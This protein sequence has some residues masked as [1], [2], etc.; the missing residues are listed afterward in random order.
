MVTSLFYLQVCSTP[1]HWA[2]SRGHLN[3]AMCLIS[4]GADVNAKDYVRGVIYNFRSKLLLV[5]YEN[6]SVLAKS[7]NPTPLKSQ[8]ECPLLYPGRATS[9]REPYPHTHTHTQ[10]HRSG[11]LGCV[12]ARE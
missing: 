8:F 4:S 5:N 11:L 7:S 1:L 2:S 10:T 12:F 3:V 9:A 6:I